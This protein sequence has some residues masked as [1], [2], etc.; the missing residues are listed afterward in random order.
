MHG[1]HGE[2]LPLL[3][4]EQAASLPSYKFKSYTKTDKQAIS[5]IAH[6]PMAQS[7]SYHIASP[8]KVMF[9]WCYAQGNL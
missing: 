8:C 2:K 6:M 7:A 4:V 1:Y 3:S 5:L 9:T